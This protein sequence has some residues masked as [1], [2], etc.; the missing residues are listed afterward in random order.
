MKNILKPD[1]YLPLTILNLKK[2]FI[3]L[4]RKIYKRKPLKTTEVKTPLVLRNKD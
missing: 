1:R 2:K 3:T 4:L